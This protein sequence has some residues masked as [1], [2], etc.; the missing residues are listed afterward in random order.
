MIVKIEVP[1]GTSVEE[2]AR[3]VREAVRLEAERRAMANALAEAA[4]GAQALADQVVVVVEP[5]NPEAA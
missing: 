5:I 2:I 1:D 3:Y 4:S